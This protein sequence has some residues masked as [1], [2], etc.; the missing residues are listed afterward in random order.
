M[1]GFVYTIEEVEHIAHARVS[2]AVEA[3]REGGWDGV[4]E[5]AEV[6]RYRG[7]E[8]GADFADALVHHV[9][10]EVDDLP[11]LQLW[12][13]LCH[14]YDDGEITQLPPELKGEV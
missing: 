6:L 2:A 11:D 8:N 14:W 3:M 9:G 12:D 1:K 7:I 4:D 5:I 10:V 13:L